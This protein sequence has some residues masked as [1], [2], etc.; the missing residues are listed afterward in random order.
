[1]RRGVVARDAAMKGKSMSELDG[2]LALVTGA[3]GRIGRAT[4]LAMAAAGAR[5]VASD[6]D[7]DGLAETARL[8]GDGHAT[9]PAD[10]TTVTEV[11]RLVERAAD[12]LG[13]LSIL[14]NCAAVLAPGGTVLET[15]PEVFD[16]TMAVN[17]RA[18]YF[19]IRAALPHMLAAGGGSIVN[20]AS[21]LGVVGMAGYSPYAVSKIGMQQLTRQVALEYAAQGIRC[22]AVCPGATSR[23]GELDDTEQRRAFRDATIAQYPIG[24]LATPDEM[25]RVVVFLAG[26]ASSFMNGAVV[27]ADG[28]YTIQ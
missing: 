28:G 14:V 23:P 8:L 5:V 4:A 27:V 10:L 22:N 17:T 3:A 21:I 9:V 24:R 15:T 20:V 2:G 25:A 12:T 26:A 18:P 19:A 16:R 6:F 7:P 1:M 11:E 13:G